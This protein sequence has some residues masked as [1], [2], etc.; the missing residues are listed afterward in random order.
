MELSIILT[1]TILFC[2]MFL[3][4]GL[5]GGWIFK[6]YQVERIYGIRNIHPEFLDNNGNIIPDEVLAVRFEEGFF[7]GEEYD[8]EDDENEEE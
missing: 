3:F 7:D 8:D 2:V 4:I 5:I 1:F 6:Q